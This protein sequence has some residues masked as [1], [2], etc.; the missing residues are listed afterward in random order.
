M[1]ATLAAMLSLLAASVTASLAFMAASA[2]AAAVN[3]VGPSKVDVLMEWA[4]R[5]GATVWFET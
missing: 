2:T 4:R 5:N 1:V 3:N